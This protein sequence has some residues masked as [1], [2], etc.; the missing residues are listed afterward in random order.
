MAAQIKTDRKVACARS[1]AR[2]RY[3]PTALFYFAST[4]VPVEV[5]RDCAYS[6]GCHHDLQL[7]ELSAGIGRKL[8]NDMLGSAREHITPN[9]FLFV[10]RA[11][12]DTKRL[13][14]KVLI[15]GIPDDDDRGSRCGFHA[16]DR[17]SQL[18]FVRADKHG[19]AKAQYEQNLSTLLARISR[20]RQFLDKQAVCFFGGRGRH[21]QAHSND[22]L[23]QFIDCENTRKENQ[24]T[25]FHVNI[26]ALGVLC[27][28]HELGLHLYLLLRLVA[29][30]RYAVG[31][32][33]AI[34]VKPD[35]RNTK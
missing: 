8:R 1:G 20:G 16:F 30:Y 14:L 29:A 24:V 28:F 35:G 15:A 4:G 9:Y 26:I 12:F 18:L 7:A 13:D 6:I 21:F 2:L 33:V 27:P 34:E 17:A 11:G 3:T 22:A 10:G 25:A 23:I 31:L 5:P 32:V 19:D